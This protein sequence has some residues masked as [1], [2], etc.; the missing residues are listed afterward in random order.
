MSPVWPI[1]RSI[2]LVHLPLIFFHKPCARHPAPPPPSH[3]WARL[4]LPSGS[5]RR[6]KNY[7][8]WRKTC[9]LS[10]WL[11][12][13]FKGKVFLY[14]V[15]KFY[16][17]NFSHWRVTT[18]WIIKTGF[19]QYLSI[20]FKTVFR[21]FSHIYCV[22]SICA[23]GV[24]LFLTRCAIQLAVGAYVDAYRQ[25]YVGRYIGTDTHFSRN[26]FNKPGMWKNHLS[27][28]GSLFAKKS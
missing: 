7:L 23:T 27:S 2:S 28:K 24:L 12:D 15:W 9:F 14:N 20:G 5:P 3:C 17:R 11:E 6:L 8:K 22:Y 18:L 26:I 16:T 19:S 4:I 13:N 10:T 21:R 1:S 25:K